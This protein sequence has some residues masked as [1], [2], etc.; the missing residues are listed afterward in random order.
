MKL[1]ANGNADVCRSVFDP[2]ND[3]Q[4]AYTLEMKLLGNMLL[5]HMT[6]QKF[7]NNPDEQRLWALARTNLEQSMMWAVKAVT[8]SNLP[9][10]VDEKPV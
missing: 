9:E 1:D 6:A 2:I 10:N 7:T 8:T 4:K 5:A 3:E